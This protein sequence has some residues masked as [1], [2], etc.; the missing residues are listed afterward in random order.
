MKRFLPTLFALF[1]FL[2]A[3][4]Q[5]AGADASAGA[6]VPRSIWSTVNP[7]SAVLRMVPMGTVHHVSIHHTET[8]IPDSVREDQR[9][10]NIQNYHQEI[11]G[12]GDIAYHFLIG[13]SGTVYEGR[14]EKYAASSGTIYLTKAQ[15]EAAPQNS[16]G[17]TEAAKPDD[18]AKPGHSKGHLT[19]CFIG[20]FEKELPTKAALDSM[21]KLVARKL[22]ENGLGTDA[23]M[24]H[25]EIACWSDCPGQALYD[26]F[27]GPSRKRDG[28]G[29]AFQSIEAALARLRD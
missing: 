20:N 12:W 4:A 17:V 28:R 14:S 18:L 23:V 26:W 5:N 7:D 10:R 8:P 29:P 22:K 1:P 21:A 27:R 15:W 25:R 16:L 19:V 11:Q 24:L 3:S 9:L 13:P 6:K 2:G